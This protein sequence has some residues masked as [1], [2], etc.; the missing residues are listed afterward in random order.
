MNV[1]L[2]WLSDYVTL[3]KSE[4]ILTDKLT[5]IG[6]M[7]DKQKVIQ[8][9]AVIDLELR[10]NRA[11]MFG[12][13][14]VA[15]DVSAVFNVPLTLP[16]ISALPKTDPAMP[17]IHA[18]PSIKHL[19]K[20]YIAVH[21]DVTVGPSPKWLADRLKAYGIDPIN[22]VVDVT[23]YV[24]VETSHPMHAFDADKLSSGTLYLRLAKSGEKFE[25]IQQGTTLTLTK[26]DIAICD[27]R[28]V[29]CL[30]CI[31]G[32]ATKVTDVTKNIIL[33]TAV[34]DA[35]NCRRT[36]RRHKIA[37]EGGNR[38]EKHQDPNELPFA[39]ARAI[40]I[41]KDIAKT[42]SIS[43]ISDYY[44]DPVKPLVLQFN[45]RSISRLVGIS[46]PDKD[47]I[48]ILESLGC[49]VQPTKTHL[50]VSV[51]TFR[52]D[53]KQEADI[54]EEIIR[55]YGYEKIPTQ[56]LSGEL[57][58]AGTPPHILFENTIRTILQNLQLNEVITSTLIENSV[59]ATYEQHGKFAPVI[60][61]VNAP[62]PE[63]ATLRP[64]MLPNLVRYAKRSL[65]FRQERIAFFELGNVYLQPKSKKYQHKMTLG[66]IMGG[67][68]PISWNQQSSGLTFFDIKGVVT[69]LAEALG[70]AISIH[71]DSKHPSLADPQATIM[72][73]DSFIGYIGAIQKNILQTEGVTEPLYCAEIDIDLLMHAKKIT[74]QPYVMAPLYPPI[75]EDM[76]LTIREDLYIGPIIEALQKAHPLIHSVTLLDVYG[77]KRMLRITYIDPK[78]TLTNA[79]ITPIREKLKTIAEKHYHAVVNV[80]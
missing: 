79:D 72:T 34:Y 3:P 37:T 70:V 50:I 1:P 14:G 29:Q 64:S 17:L 23:N 18:D 51:P 77:N 68:T 15:R 2:T 32:A 44:P 42:T 8:G 76:S 45:P 59:I 6:H 66:I 47:V 49:S 16:T 36:A 19:V 11:D 22:N 35:A 71:P 9:G 27:A 10:G 67:S 39:L 28:G 38:H 21:L 30:T 40:E 24:M 5:M 54:V 61:L 80:A 52:T 31:G 65:G 63:I 53:I 7:L 58:T 25:T 57:P 75:V 69:G 12:I 46:V 20:R 74:T 60:T 55:I 13:I 4:K 43:D 56:T 78:R 62:D 26:E 48:H 41:L 33:E 73:G